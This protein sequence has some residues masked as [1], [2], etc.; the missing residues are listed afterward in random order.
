MK[1]RCVHWK[2]TLVPAYTKT[3]YNVINDSIIGLNAVINVHLKWI[4]KQMG[5]EQTYKLL[6]SKGN[7][8]KRTDNLQIRANIYKQC[9][10]QGINFQ[11]T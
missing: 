5:F 4:H 1:I 10:Q 8:K 9:D 6:H 2:R 11:N 3:I 7:H